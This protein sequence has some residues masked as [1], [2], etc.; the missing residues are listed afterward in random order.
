MGNDWPDFNS[1]DDGERNQGS[2]HIRRTRSFRR[3]MGTIRQ[4]PIQRGIPSNRVLYR[5]LANDCVVNGNFVAGV[6]GREQPNGLLRYSNSLVCQQRHLVF[7]IG[8]LSLETGVVDAMTADGAY[9]NNLEYG[10]GGFLLIMITFLFVDIFDTAGT[11]YSVGRQAGYVDE[12]D[13]LM[14]SDEAFMSDS[15][16]LL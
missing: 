9:A 2:N 15:V 14:N 4:R 12:N 6:P 5:S 10:L 1:R 7:A 13:E 16:P 11:L 3:R 8:A